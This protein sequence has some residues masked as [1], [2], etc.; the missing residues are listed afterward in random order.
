MS[1]TEEQSYYGKGWQFPPVFNKLEKGVVMV[2][3]EE[4][5]KQSLEILL[6]TKPGERVMQPNFGCNLELM[7]F[8]P[9]TASL[10]TYMKDLIRK[11]ILFYE[12][13]IDVNTIDLN[14]ENIE[15][16]LILIEVDYTIRS[17]NSRFNFVYPFY[18][19]EGIDPNI[20]LRSSD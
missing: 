15:A 7:L 16:G 14:V 1:Q 4:D 6:S 10:I 12:A 3:D 2:S 19:E 9:I 11:A 18:L 5:I 17:T 13:R 8:E 20:V